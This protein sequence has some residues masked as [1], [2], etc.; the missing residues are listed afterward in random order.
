VR[1]RLRAWLLRVLRVPPRPSLPRGAENVR[2]FRAAPAFYRYRLALWVLAQAG[3][4]LGLTFGLAAGTASVGEFDS[5]LLNRLLIAAEAF[6]WGGFLLQL[7][8]SLM[9][10][11][12]DFELR[13]YIVSDRSLRIREGVWHVLE[14]TMTFANVQQIS[15]RQNPLQRLL[16][17]ADV[18]VRSAGGGEGKGKRDGGAGESAHEA[19][20]R[21][22]DNAEEIRTAVQ[23]RV[24]RHRDSGLGDP[25]DAAPADAVDRVPVRAPATDDEVLVAA[26]ALHREVRALR[27]RAPWER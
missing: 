15:I 3:A 27:E 8:L 13:W 21:G 7:P 24:R 22:V 17:I 4:L 26:R 19:Y 10:V 2:V 20:F 23:E 5:S 14:K 18:R 6:A 9:A 1:E 11:R 25:D 12:L 16:G